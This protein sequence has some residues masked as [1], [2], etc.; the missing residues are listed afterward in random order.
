[1]SFSTVKREW[2]FPDDVNRAPPWLAGSPPSTTGGIVT[3]TA[4]TTA[5]AASAKANP[6]GRTSAIAMHTNTV[7]RKA[8][9]CVCLVCL[10][11]LMCE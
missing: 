5:A 3:R 6:R 10:V 8:N 4:A 9:G 1:M 2:M 7:V 11:C